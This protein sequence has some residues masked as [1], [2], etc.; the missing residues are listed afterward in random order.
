M[1]RERG[2]NMLS[3]PLFEGIE[4]G[5]RT[6][7]FGFIEQNNASK[8][9]KENITISEG[10]SPLSLTVCEVLSNLTSSTQQ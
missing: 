2:N 9:S 4:Y 3:T 7:A 10:K 6:A 1:S 8:P 5:K